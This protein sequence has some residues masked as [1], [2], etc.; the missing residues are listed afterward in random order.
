MKLKDKTMNNEQQKAKELATLL[1]A[2]ADGKQLQVKSGRVWYDYSLNAMDIFIKNFYD[3]MYEFRIKP[4]TRRVEY[5]LDD[6]LIGKIVI[7]KH[8][9]NVVKR[10]IISQDGVSVLISDY[11]SYTDKTWYG[12]N[13]LAELFTWSDNSPCYKEVE[14]E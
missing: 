14:C 10:M 3:T 7:E 4:K 12:Y 13:Q 8:K 2:F 9:F 11:Q 6:D 5:N 1:N